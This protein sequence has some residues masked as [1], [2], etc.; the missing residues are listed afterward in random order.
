MLQRSAVNVTFGT[1]ASLDD[2]FT[3]FD[4]S[5][6]LSGIGV[7]PN[8]LIAGASVRFTI[9]PASNA[10]LTISLGW[11]FPYKDFMGGE[12][13]GNR[14]TKVYS[15]A[16]EAASILLESSGSSTAS[17]KA[18]PSAADDILDWAGFAS[19]LISPSSSLPTWLGDSLLNTLHHARSTFWLEDGRFRQWESFSC[20]NVDSVHN[21][22]ERH[23]PYLL[24]WP[25]ILPSKML[26]WAKGQQSDG[27]IKEQLAC[28]CVAATPNSSTRRAGALWATRL[29]NVYY[30]SV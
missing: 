2:L 4:K 27:M 9:P 30:L 11:Y 3:S 21:D 26:A 7:E 15:S 23:L 14:Y 5:G 16:E 25:H 22:G 24:L 17:S 8:G 28:G 13:I 19:A 18:K 12:I 29:F 10:S 1:A 20:V 6:D